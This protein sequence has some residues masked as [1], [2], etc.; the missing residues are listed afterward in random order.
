ML[1]SSRGDA[2]IAR[3]C[4]VPFGSS[5]FCKEPFF[6]LQN[7]NAP[8]ARLTDEGQG[9]GPSPEH[10]RSMDSDVTHAM[11]KNEFTDR[12][13]AVEGRLYRV[14]YGMLRN[15]Q[16]RNDAVQEAVI[17]AW[18]N[19]DRLRD[20][21]IFETWLTRILINECYNLLR[22]RKRVVPLEAVSEPSAVQNGG[23]E[24]RD[25]VLA[26]S[27]DKRIVVILHYMEGYRT[28]EIASILRLPE[29]TV[30]SRLKRARKDLKDMLSE[31]GV[32]YE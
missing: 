27:P 28:R 30:K 23:A 2:L 10:D 20:E 15:E 8:P 32:E 17:R 21:A 24:L 5:R 25:A 29:G 22:A 26:L 4:A 7:P 18:Q 16:D 14:A 13:L 9:K 3:L 31:G 11:N 1:Q 19:L 12:V 6:Y